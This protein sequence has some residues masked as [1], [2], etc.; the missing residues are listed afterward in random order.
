[1]PIG[2]LMKMEDGELM[3]RVF[4]KYHCPNCGN[5][6]LESEI[7]EGN[8]GECHGRLPKS[9]GLLSKPFAGF[10]SFDACMTHMTSPKP[11]GQGYDEDTARKV[12]G[13]LQAREEK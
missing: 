2:D 5:R 8:C 6:L 7:E 4:S 10:A 11:D 1:M 3:L 13:S 12:C 9:D